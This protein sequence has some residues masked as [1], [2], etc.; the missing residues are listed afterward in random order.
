MRRKNDRITE[1]QMRKKY[2]I[3]RCKHET[4]EYQN[5]KNCFQIMT[6]YTKNA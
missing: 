1:V 5:G 3:G 4:T 2:Q 6:F